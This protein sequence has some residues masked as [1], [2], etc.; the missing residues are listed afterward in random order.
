MESYP[1]RV[2]GNIKSYDGSRAYDEV[3]F[4]DLTFLMNWT[5][6]FSKAMD[7]RIQ[8][9]VKGPHTNHSFIFEARTVDAVDGTTLR[10][11]IT[12]CKRFMSTADKDVPIIL[13]DLTS[14]HWKDY[15]KLA[16]KP[17][18]D[19]DPEACSDE[20]DTMLQSKVKSKDG[21][22]L[23]S[24][25]TLLGLRTFKISN[26]INYIFN[27]CKNNLNSADLTIAPF[28]G[29][30]KAHMVYDYCDHVRNDKVRYTDQE[31]QDVLDFMTSNF[32]QKL[33]NL[34]AGFD[35]NAAL[36]FVTRIHGNNYESSTIFQL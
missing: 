15:K 12:S 24:D 21:I 19:Y 25:T 9:G 22:E 20:I 28:E 11:V 16:N 4:I 33:V 34:E 1:A 29:K 36:D 2:H 3:R 18:I 35:D 27:I 10:Q 30:V 5:Q 31:K 14:N 13:P 23:H 17:I 32:P 26:S 7:K 6:F 8:L